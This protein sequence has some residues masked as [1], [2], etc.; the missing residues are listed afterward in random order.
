[1]KTQSQ[2]VCSVCAG[3]VPAESDFCPAC[4]LRG[5]I[6]DGIEAGNLE[7]D[8][9]DLLVGRRLDHYEI[10]LRDDGEPLELGRGAMGVTYKAVDVNLRC[11]VALKIIG[12]RYIGDQAACQRFVRE[13]Q[14]AASVRH[15]NVASVFHLG[16]LQQNYF[17]AMEFVAGESLEKLIRRYGSLNVGDGLAILNYAAGGLDGI[18]KQNLIHRDIKPSN[19]M[20]TTEGDQIVNAKIIDLG[21]AK[22]GTEAGASSEVSAIGTFAG[23]VEYASPEQFAGVSGDI[24]SDLYSLGVTFWEMLTGEPPFAGSPSELMYCHQRKS[25]P[26][27][28]LVGL[29][30]PIVALL[31]VLLAKDPG[32]RFQN[33]SQLLRVIPSVVEAIGSGKK[34]PAHKLRSSSFDPIHSQ[35]QPVD[36]NKKTGLKAAPKGRWPVPLIAA[37]LLLTGLLWF[38]GSRTNLLNAPSSSISRS[39]RSIAVLPFD[40]SDANQEES[41]LANGIQE[42]ILNDLARVAQLKVI[43][44]RSVM[45]YRAEAKRDVRQIAQALGVSNVLEGTVQR[46][47][48]KIGVTAELIDATNGRTIWTDSYNRDQTDI[49]AIQSEIARAIVGKLNAS[50]SPEE[51]QRIAAKPTD[52]IKA[53]D[54]YLK[55]KLIV[56]QAVI[57]W[58]T[59]ALEKP[60]RDA[61]NLLEKAVDL[62]PNFALA[63]CTSA[64]AHDFIYLLYEHTPERRALADA[65]LNKALRL[66]RD[67]PEVHLTYAKH[68]HWAYGN[69]EAARLQLAIAKQGLPNDSGVSA[70]EADI[71][72][73]EGKFDKSIQEFNDALT[74]DPLNEN[75]ISNLALCYG[76]VRQYHASAQLFHRLAELAPDL[77]MVDVQK[78]VVVDFN[79][80]GDTSAVESAIAQL[81]RSQADDRETLSLQLAIAITREEWQKANQLIERLGGDDE[82]E[83][84]YGSVPVPV[85]CYSI[86]VAAVQGQPLSPSLTKTREELN[87]RVQR[88]PANAALLSSLAL[89]DALLGDKAKANPEAERALELTPVAKDAMHG[90]DILK[91]VAAVHVW[92]GELEKAFAELSSLAKMPKGISYG[93]LKCDRY[94][95]PIRNDP[96]YKMILADLAPN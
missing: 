91:N 31:E 95:G 50:L 38:W 32:E 35:T 81:P 62:D 6:E 34:V 92:T 25:L 24:R 36:K 94:W 67:L 20:V 28:K 17:Y 29:P 14:A 42:E 9:V 16:T 71:D 72:R 1:V 39:D 54:L 10:V 76:Y 61:I 75:L 51:E 66:R 79:E 26:I 82:G 73:H 8:P 58:D 90:P 55:A 43:S 84:G 19:I 63:Y 2:R 45:Q 12:A 22:S 56:D 69:Y 23:T 89:V 3:W 41:Y 52:S 87:D 64:I 44:P 18:W 53:Y 47:G 74:R 93:E 59:G 48:D 83:F 5:A 11:P 46:N 30:H 7:F 85:G 96:R 37:A 80:R 4:L 86:L 77:S 88:E 60:L 15:P 40:S 13:A 78:A 49:F 21:L 57:N 68:L 65:A 33:P 70:L 27:D